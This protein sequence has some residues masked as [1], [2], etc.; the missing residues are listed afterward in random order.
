[1]HTNRILTTSAILRLALLPLATS[2]TAKSSLWKATSGSGTLYLQGSVHIL[3]ADAYPL[4]PAIEN[5]YA[6]SDAV[7][8]ETDMAEM[9]T[10][11]TQQAI[12]AKAM[13]KPGATLESTLDPGTYQALKAEFAKASLPAE[14]F[15]AFKPWFAALTLTLTRLQQMGFDPALGLDQHFHAKAAADGKATIGLETVEFQINLIDSIAQND[16]SAFLNRSL[17]DLALIETQLG[18]M[19]RAWKEGDGDALGKFMRESFADYPGLYER[20]VTDRNQAWAEKL[21]LLAKQGKTHMVVVGA[22]HLPGQGGLLERL[23]AKG[24]SIEQL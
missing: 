24:Y 12:L 8:F 18:E 23:A 6:Q 10:P 21:D 13:L 4:A 2:A 16:Q 22:A 1:M 9:L 15:Q 7:V 14:A 3:K 19:M 5:A 11:E 17:K 20:F